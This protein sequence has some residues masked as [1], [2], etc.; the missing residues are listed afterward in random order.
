MGKSEREAGSWLC[1]QSCSLFPPAPS[2]PPQPAGTPRPPSLQ[3]PLAG[4]QRFTAQRAGVETRA[5]PTRALGSASLSLAVAVGTDLLSDPPKFMGEKLGAQG[6]ALARAGDR[7]VSP[8]PWGGPPCP[9]APFAFP[10]DAAGP[11]LLAL[12]LSDGRAAAAAPVR[13]SQA[14][15]G[16][17]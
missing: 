14:Q 6:T 8:L 4:A 9:P 7:P 12:L 10:R 2:L 13:A 15:L 3:A 11:L 1:A 5:L 16:A 17:L